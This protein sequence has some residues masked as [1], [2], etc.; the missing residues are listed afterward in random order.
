[1]S[2]CFN[3]LQKSCLTKSLPI[4]FS[5][6]CHFHIFPHMV[7]YALVI[8]YVHLPIFTICKSIPPVFAITSKIPCNALYFLKNDIYLPNCYIMSKNAHTCIAYL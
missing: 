2:K 1:M 6:G 7:P 5:S 4:L 3:K 8:S